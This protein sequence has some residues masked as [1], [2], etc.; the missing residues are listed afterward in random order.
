MSEMKPPPPPPPRPAD[1]EAGTDLAGK[2]CSICQT[3]ILAGER[4]LTCSHCGLPFHSECWNENR[5]CSAYG[6]KG[7]PPTVKTNPVVEASSNAWAGEK[8]CPN[9][10]KTIKGEAMKCRFCGASFNTRDVISRTEFSTRE[11]EGA[12]YVAARNKVIG[13]F[14]L[15]SAACLAPIGLVLVGILVGNKELM[16][17]NY[18]RLPM[19]LK[20]VLI[21]SL[22][23]ACLLLVIMVMVLVFD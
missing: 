11:Y 23:I 5:G 6:C 7:A 1:F 19:T 15:S 21:S 3:A 10:G 20:A 17:I 13:L 22:G 2:L 9:C 8:P 16:G 4:V 12:E 14:L 18:N